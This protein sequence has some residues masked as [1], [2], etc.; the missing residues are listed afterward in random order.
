MPWRYFA[1][2]DNVVLYEAVVV[3][4]L[5]FVLWF[6]DFQT[7]LRTILERYFTIDFNFFFYRHRDRNTKTVVFKGS[8]FSSLVSI[9]FFD[10]FVFHFIYLLFFNLA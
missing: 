8:N 1:T 7:M 6:T 3:V 2:V 9:I 5:L 10:T 4:T